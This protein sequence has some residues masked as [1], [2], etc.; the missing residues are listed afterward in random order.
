MGLESRWGRLEIGTGE[1]QESFDNRFWLFPYLWQRTESCC[2]TFDLPAATFSSQT[3]S[4]VSRSFRIA[5][6]IEPKVWFGMV[7]PCVPIVSLPVGHDS[8]VSVA[9][10]HI[11]YNT[12]GV[13]KALSRSYDAN[14]FIPG[15][16]DD[17]TANSFPM[18]RW[19]PVFHVNFGFTQLQL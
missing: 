19:F 3:S 18:S 13:Y 11:S 16:S 1:L 4:T 15:A 7:S 12:Y 2:H 17:D 14:I 6:R 10:V 8:V 9:V 5:V